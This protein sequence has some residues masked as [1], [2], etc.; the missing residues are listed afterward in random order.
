MSK[1]LKEIKRKKKVSSK[2]HLLGEAKI[3]LQ[4]EI[5]FE[6]ELRNML[7]TIKRAYIEEL[8]SK[9]FIKDS[10][11]DLNSVFTNVRKKALKSYPVAK[12]IKMSRTLSKRANVFNA[13][14]FLSNISVGLG[15]K[16]GADYDAPNI[17]SFL[18]LK[19]MEHTSLIKNLRDDT[20]QKIESE[21]LQ[22]FNNGEHPQLLAKRLNDRF[23]I[24]RKRAKL[25]AR[26]EI[27]NLNAQLSAKR[28]ENAGIEFA[29]WVTANDGDRVRVTHRPLNGMVYMIGVGLPVVNQGKRV[30]IQPAEEINCR[31]RAKPIFLD[32]DVKI[33][34]HYIQ[35]IKDGKITYDK[36]KADISKNKFDI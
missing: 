2:V 35:A 4:L 34:S 7:E 27:K 10:A 1:H 11:Q 12:L 22:S 33:P 3:P 28:F 16:L 19:A 5:Q 9:G 24:G 25:I 13:S 21:V 14:N 26:N 31:C 30:Y 20:L 17:N 36:F 15:I 29:V 23:L 32:K 18:K 6:R 8:K